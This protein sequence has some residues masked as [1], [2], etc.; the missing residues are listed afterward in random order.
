MGAKLTNASAT[1]SVVITIHKNNVRYRVFPILHVI[2]I[3]TAT[4]VG[5]NKTSLL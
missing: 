1:E 5:L 2:G 3:F 4:V